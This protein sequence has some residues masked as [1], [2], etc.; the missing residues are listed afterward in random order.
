MTHAR[1]AALVLLP[2]ALL[3]AAC[4]EITEA[5]LE[6][7]IALEVDSDVLGLNDSM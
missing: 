3:A 2:G 6:T 5:D 4:G 1:L 7:L